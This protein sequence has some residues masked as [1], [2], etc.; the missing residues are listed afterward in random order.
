MSGN[1][2]MS[3]GESRDSVWGVGRDNTARTVAHVGKHR[4]DSTR[5]TRIQRAQAFVK[6]SIGWLLETTE[7]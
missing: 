1:H 4:A 2:A 3:R 5:K 6:R 7:V